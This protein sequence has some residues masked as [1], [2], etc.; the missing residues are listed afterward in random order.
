M[1]S[2]VWL[3]SKTHSELMTASGDGT[4]KL[5]DTRMFSS[6]RETFIIDLSNK[7]RESLGDINI[8]QGAS[9]LSYDS[10]IPSKYLVGTEAGRVICCSRKGRSQ[11]ETITAQFRGHQGS[12]RYIERNPAASKYFLSLGDTTVKVWAD[13]V[14]E[15]PVWWA[16]TGAHHRL[17]HGCWAP[18]RPSVLLTADLSG[19]VSAR[20]R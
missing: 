8:A 4:V 18:A 12:V 10:T 5:W 19:A 13:D 3:S 9:F 1:Y 15:S 2:L 14:Y 11:P 6:S 17:T 16:R 7:D 20:V